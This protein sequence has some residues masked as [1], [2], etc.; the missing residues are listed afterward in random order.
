MA[1]LHIG[2][3][4]EALQKQSA[5][6]VVMPD[7]AKA[8]PPVVYQLHGLSDDYTMWQRRTS[9]ERYAD[10]HGLM[11]VMPDGGRSWYSDAADGTG[12]YEKHILE[13]VA[14]IDRTFRTAGGPRGRA[15]GGLSM[16]GYGAM[17]I[18][19]KHP[20]LFGSIAAHSGAL[21]TMR[22]HREKRW[23]E[24]AGIFG[25]TFPDSEDCFHLAELPGVKPAIRID[26]GV[27]DYLI[28]DNRRFHAHLFEIGVPHDYA[29]YPGSHDW[30]Y[31]DA[32]IDRA[33]R[34]HRE[35][36]EQG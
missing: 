17:K 12:A 29:E 36:F 16:G 22:Q 2:F 34:F 14:F 33:L 6:F 19:L 18:G 21:D 8:P 32:H 7:G 13:V 15:I 10:R 24:M 35:I 5:M 1:L 9:I 28:Q 11:I 20:E 3:F 31:W 26:C 4:S 27:D 23:P 30:E 25:S